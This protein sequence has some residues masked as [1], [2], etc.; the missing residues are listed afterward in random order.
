MAGDTG[1]HRSLGPR[2]YVAHLAVRVRGLAAEREAGEAE[3]E[4]EA[5]RLAVASTHLAA[6]TDMI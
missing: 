3:A 4:A 2:G 6:N 1:R 5:P